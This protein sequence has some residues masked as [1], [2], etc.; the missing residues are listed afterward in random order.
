[1]E[2]S[3]GKQIRNLRRAAEMTQEQ[4]AEK[5]GISFQAISKWENNI[6]MPD[7]IMIPELARVFGVSTDIIFS[8]DLQAV[9]EDIETYVDKAYKLRE[10]NP[11]E[12]RRILEE[13][14]AKYPGNETLLNNLLYVINYNEN[15]DETIKVA[16]NLVKATRESDI[17][18]DALRF[19]AYAY[20]AKGD[21]ESAAAALEE[22]PEIYFTKLSEVAYVLSG[23]VKYEATIKQKWISFEMLL[24]M[25]WRIVECYE[26]AGKKEQ[27]IEEA[28]KALAVID[29]LAGGPNSNYKNY[30]D[31]F[32]KFSTP[33]T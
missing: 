13:G 20:K 22:I 30:R 16:G 33:K 26:E 32:E 9:E 8:Y 4:L 31:L 10:R 15:P 25:M 3:I 23:P 19:M 21:L 24:E 12:G 17:K 27:A 2:L 11:E 14:L 7:V 5:L 1:M 6:S 18:Y 28:K 29:V